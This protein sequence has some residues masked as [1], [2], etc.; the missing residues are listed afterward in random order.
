MSKDEDEDTEAK[1]NVFTTHFHTLYV[2]TVTCPALPLTRNCDSVL[3]DEAMVRSAPLDSSI[4]DPDGLE[5]TVLDYSIL[6]GNSGAF[7]SIDRTT[8]DVFL[9][10][11]LD[12]DLGPSQF[13]LEILVSD[14]MFNTTLQLDIT[15]EDVN[16]N[17]PVP[18]RPVFSGSV[19][20]EQP[21]FTPVLRVNF[22]D[23]DIGPISYFL[24][25]SETDFAILDPSYGA[26]VTNRVFNY[27]AGD[28]F[29]SFQV[30]ASDGVFVSNATVEITVLDENDNTLTGDKAVDKYARN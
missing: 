5:N 30:S 15:V 21:R 14:G 16:D 19:A 11:P 6:S 27:Q 7:F 13:T 2:H 8:G 18:V 20:E 3:G 25:P 1:L 9:A 26:I 28:R 23:A 22:T 12:R 4:V 10:R 24:D 17:P 29:F